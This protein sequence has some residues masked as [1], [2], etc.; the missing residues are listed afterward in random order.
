MWIM[1]T[2]TSNAKAAQTAAAPKVEMDAKQIES[3]KKSY[4]PKTMETFISGSVIGDSAAAKEIRKASAVLARLSVLKD[5]AEAMEK[6]YGTL[7]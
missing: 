1:S 5:S 3:W 2:S 6:A 4:E 7:Y